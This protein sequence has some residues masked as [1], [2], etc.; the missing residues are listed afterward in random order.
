MTTSSYAVLAL[1]SLR[2]WTGYEL[3]QQAARS[4]RYAWP[5]SERLLYSEPKK[6]VGL[7][8]ATARTE[9][10][11]RRTRNLYEITDAGRE[12]LSSWTQSPPSP[13]QFEAEPLLRLLFADI[14]TVEDLRAALDTFDAD[15]RALH[16][17]VLEVMRGYLRGEH[18][19]PGRT[20]LSVLFGTFQLELFT[21]IEEWVAF[22]QREIA[23]WPTTRDIGM[24]E[25]VELITRIISEGGSVL[26]HPAL[27]APPVKETTRPSATVER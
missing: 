2:P 8:Y 23:D 24:T 22:A 3:T 6:L 7:G 27:A 20:H 1:L 13:P 19:F 15:T 16:A 4:L 5:K 18:P 17:A 10:V 14:G 12:V 9:Q 26:N 11:G 21:L 25:R